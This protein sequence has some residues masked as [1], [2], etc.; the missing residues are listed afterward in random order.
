MP[1][2]DWDLESAGI[3]IVV[4]LS[5]HLPPQASEKSGLTNL[6]QGS[7]RILFIHWPIEDGDPPD[8]TLMDLLTVFIS[9]AIDEDRTVFIHCAAGVNR[10]ALAA[11]LVVRHRLNITGYA[12][13]R[14][15]QDAR[16]GTLRNSDF[17]AFL[18]S[19]PVPDPLS[20]P[21]RIAPWLT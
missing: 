13:G 7:G 19:L 5:E 16:P 2:P 17:L 21:A 4:T 14:L 12:A 10:S 20:H 9:N 11:A 15:V 18:D 1:R 3:S 6:A 8:M